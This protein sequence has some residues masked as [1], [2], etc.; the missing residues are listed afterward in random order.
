MGKGVKVKKL[1]P[2]PKFDNMKMVNDIALLEL[3]KPLKCGKTTTTICLPTNKEVYKD[4]QKL[5]IA[6]W[7]KTSDKEPDGREKDTL[8]EGV[9]EQIPSK[10]CLRPGLP[11]NTVDQYHCGVGTKKT[12]CQVLFIITIT[13]NEHQ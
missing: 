9:M 5:I 4:G 3:E 10:K 11:K 6:G 7:G 1:I 13:C 12:S 8:K 2:H